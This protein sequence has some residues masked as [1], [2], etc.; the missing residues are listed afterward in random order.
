MSE[1]LSGAVEEL[2]QHLKEQLEEAANTKKLINSLLKRMGQEPRYTDVAVEHRGA[3]RADEYYGKPLASAIQLYLDR[4]RQAVPAEEILKGLE[5][6]GFD[7]NSQGWTEK[8]RFRNLVISMAKNSQ[9]F[10]RLPNGTFG[11]RA[12]YDEAMLRKAGRVGKED[13]IEAESEPPQEPDDA[14]KAKTA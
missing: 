8:A 10:H 14:G 2:E 1:K 6:G 9:T 13:A 5:Q 7:F 11:L 4:R 12:W 3:M